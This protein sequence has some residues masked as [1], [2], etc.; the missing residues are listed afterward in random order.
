MLGYAWEKKHA[1]SS[2]DIGMKLTVHMVVAVPSN[3]DSIS[4]TVGL[5]MIETYGAEEP[6]HPERPIHL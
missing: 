4:W 3:R 6:R 5:V 1:T 2:A